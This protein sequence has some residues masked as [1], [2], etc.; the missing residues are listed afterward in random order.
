LKLVV[1]QRRQI[2]AEVQVPAT[3]PPSTAVTTPVTTAACKLIPNVEV[4]DRITGRTQVV[5]GAGHLVP[6][7]IPASSN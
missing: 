4:L 2:R 6:S 5:L 1:D 7:A 3:P